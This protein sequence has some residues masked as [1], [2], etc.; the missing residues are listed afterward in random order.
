MALAAA[1]KLAAPTPMVAARHPALRD[2]RPSLGI[3]GWAVLAV[4]TVRL[5]LPQRDVR[6][7]NLVGDLEMPAAG[8]GLEVGWRIRDDGRSWP[9]YSLDT[10]LRL[11][12]PA[13]AQRRLCVFFGPGDDVRGVLCDR[14]WSLAADGDLVIEPLPGCFAGARS[15]A[16]GLA[17]FE[18]QVALVTDCGALTAYLAEIQEAGHGR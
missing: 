2:T 18:K 3:A 14:V 7:I 15:P 10:R 1:S 4:G 16:I 17:Q 9:A 12:S 13:P 6:Q 11:E 5:A 8:D